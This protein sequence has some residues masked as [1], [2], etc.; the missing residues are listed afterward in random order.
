MLAVVQVPLDAAESGRRVLHGVRSGLL[1]IADPPGERGEVGRVGTEQAAD[2]RAVS[3][4]DRVRQPRAASTRTAPSGRNR[5]EP[6]RV[7][8]WPSRGSHGPAVGGKPR[9]GV[10]ARKRLAAPSFLMPG[11]DAAHSMPFGSMATVKMKAPTA[12]GTLTIAYASSAQ[13]RLVNGARRIRRS[14]ELTGLVKM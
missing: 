4:G 14:G 1:Q 9:A 13:A 8:M 5:N 10:R 2:E 11:A 12:S 6:A 7:T 3:V